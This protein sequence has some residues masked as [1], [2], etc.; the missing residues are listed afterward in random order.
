M[1]SGAICNFMAWPEEPSNPE[2][3]W[4]IAIGRCPACLE[5]DT[6]F[7]WRAGM[8]TD[9]HDLCT[10]YHCKACDADYCWGIAWVMRACRPR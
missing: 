9:W 3:A 4:K 6:L 7:K 5:R 8:L 1:G 10:H 2:V